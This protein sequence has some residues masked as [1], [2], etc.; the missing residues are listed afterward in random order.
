MHV[1]EDS[2]TITQFFY[3]T[4]RCEDVIDLSDGLVSKEVAVLEPAVRSCRV[5]IRVEDELLAW[6]GWLVACD[7]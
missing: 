1:R 2:R 7:P 3:T 4:V 5:S 6:K